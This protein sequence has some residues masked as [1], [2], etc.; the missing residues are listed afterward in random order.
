[1]VSLNQVSQYRTGISISCRYGTYQAVPSILTHSTLRYRAVSTVP[2]LYRISTYRAYTK[3]YD[4]V[5]QI[6]V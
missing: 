1:M 6:L 5:L 2:K 4:T 3:R